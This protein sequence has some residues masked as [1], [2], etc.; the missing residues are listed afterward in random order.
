MDPMTRKQFL[1][2]VAIAG[3]A[4]VL[5]A[6]SRAAQKEKPTA[7]IK[8]AYQDHWSMISPQGLT[9]PYTSVKY[10]D[11]FIKQIAGLGFQGLYSFA[12]RLPTYRSMF[13]SPKNALEFLQARGIEKII[14][15]FFDYAYV[16]KYHA[17][18]VRETHD[19]IF[20]DFEQIM[21]NA[22]GFGMEK[23]VIMPAS[24]Y[25]QTE[26]VTDEKLHAIADLWNRVGKMTLSHGIKASFHHEFWCG[27][28]NKEDIEKFYAWTDPQYVFYF[29]D[30]AQHVIA[31]VD[32]VQLY[33]KY[34]DRCI[35]FHFKDTHNV[36]T[37][38]EYR[39]P[40]DAE[41]LAPSVARW[42]WEMGTP[43]G[44]V[45]FP[46]MMRAMKEYHYTGWVG[47]EHDKAE[48]GGGSYAESTCIAAWYIKNVLSPIYS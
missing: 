12:S 26:P 4:A 35:G 38:G 34:H 22:E 25:W 48:I 3:T 36:D 6:L 16:D 45:D 14:G 1:E 37:K 8:W 9:S 28:R 32:P 43:E 19:N 47:V 2:T 24:I 17:P 10:F 46:A 20:R 5:P 33:M 7:N 29:C 31:G 15:G 30:T 44:L 13:G 23:L 18:H 39:L 21:K 40:P 27:V 42:F 41:M 11:S